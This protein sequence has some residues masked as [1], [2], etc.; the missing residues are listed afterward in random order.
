MAQKDKSL[1]IVESPTKSKT[2]KKF[3]GKGFSIEATLG[4]IK[5][6][7]K[8]KLG[9]DIENNYEPVYEVIPGKDKVINALKKAAGK[10]SVIY[11][12]PDPDRE[13]EAIAKHVA[14]ILDNGYGDVRRATFN[15]ITE[16]AVKDA[17][18][19]AG[20]I[21]KNK[22]SAQ[23]ARRVLDRIVGYKVSPVLWKTI[24]RRLSAGRVQSVALRLICEREDEI[25]AFKPDEYWSITADFKAPKGNFKAKL[26]SIKGKKFK[27]GN[28]KE[29]DETVAGIKEESFS[30]HDVKIETKSR[31]PQPP[32]I[33]STL[34]QEAARRLRF[35]AKRTMRVAQSLYEG[36]EM[37][38][39]GSVGLITYM[40]TDSLRLS[41]EALAGAKGIISAN[42]GKE[43]LAPK[44][45]QFKNKNKAQDAHEAIRPTYFD[46]DPGQIKQYLS[47][48]QY[49]LYTLIWNRFLASQ[50]APAKILQTRI[51]SKGGIYVFRATGSRI[52]FDGFLKVYEDIK[53]E[54]GKE[55]GN[56]KLPEVEKGESLKLVGVEPKQHFTKPPPRYSEASLVKELESKGIGRPSTYAQIID[57]IRQRKYAEIEQRRF[58]PTELGRT[59]NKVLTE[60]FDRIFNVEFTAE[61]EN[62]LDKVEYGDYDWRKV[63]DDFYNPFSENLKEVEK[64]KDEIKKSTIK[65]TGIK[66]DKC[67]AEMIEKWGR[68]GKFLACSA[69]PDCKNTMPIEGDDFNQSTGEKCPE[70]EEGDLIIKNG[71]FGK[72]IACSN[73]PECKFTKA[74]SLGVKCPEEGCEGELVERRSRRGKPFYS[75]SKYPDCKYAI[76]NKPVPRECPECGFAFMVEK[77]TKAKGNFLQ[78]LQC[79]HKEFPKSDSEGESSEEKEEYANSE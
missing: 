16:K 21:D 45:R 62:E 22:V 33:T 37:G 74:I 31:N 6:L 35:S 11:L 39:A 61:M 78:C 48:D 24:S 15:E 13:G 29:T 23:Q 60:N 34:Q 58:L 66:C 10:A 68:H 12:A 57:T 59:V 7:P 30:V 44:S 77:Y 26:H 19:N 25:E 50:M 52:K 49:R 70:C 9:V 69:Y 65:A 64:R 32:F 8:K 14:E 18:K 20:K 46:Y 2:L 55:N 79:K 43:Y 5:D 53:E 72:F 38:D 71:R 42:F 3:L 67:G 47:R 54:N 17:I 76:W 4:H 28:Q 41:G 56:Q 63:I 27:L 73:Y 36:V 1:V 75:C 40:R 51:D